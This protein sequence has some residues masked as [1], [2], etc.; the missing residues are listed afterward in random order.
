MNLAAKLTQFIELTKENPDYLENR[1]IFTL[2]ICPLLVPSFMGFKFYWFQV[3]WV[4]S[5]KVKVKVKVKV[6]V[7]VEYR[8][9]YLILNNFF[10]KHFVFTSF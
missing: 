3:S 9:L 4:P 1:K 8:Y 2:S 7:K 10:A 5:F 6:N